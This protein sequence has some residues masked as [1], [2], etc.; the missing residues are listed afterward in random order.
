[1]AVVGAYASYKKHGKYTPF[2]LTT[3]SV[4][5]LLFVY[6]VTLLTWLLYVALAGL[7]I[8]AIWNMLEIRRCQ[9]CATAN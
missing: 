6:N 5:A 2:L 3:L 7:A 1:M 4:A 9:K 8:A